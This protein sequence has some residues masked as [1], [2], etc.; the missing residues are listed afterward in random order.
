[1][2]VVKK[3][4][5]AKIGQRLKQVPKPSTLRSQNYRPASP[6]GFWARIDD[7]VSLGA[8]NQW[9]YGWTQMQ[10]IA[11]GWREM[12]GGLSAAAADARAALNSI[13]ASNDAAAMEGNSVDRSLGGYPAGF[14]MQP[15]QGSPIVWMEK[16]LDPTTSAALYTFEYVNAEDGTCT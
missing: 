16:D 11:G 10:R 13:E 3:G 5:L 9:K 6:Q 7:L 12:P 8:I 4:T 14:S 2:T 15:V 1:M